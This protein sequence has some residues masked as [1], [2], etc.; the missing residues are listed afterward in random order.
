M[1]GIGIAIAGMFI[2]LWAMVAL[3]GFFDVDQLNERSR[4]E[5]E[6]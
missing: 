1:A 2:G 5:E 4:D 3:A 6:D